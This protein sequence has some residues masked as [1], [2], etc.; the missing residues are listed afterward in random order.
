MAEIPPPECIGI[1]SH[2]KGLL[3]PEHN[4]A[5]KYTHNYL[6][7]QCK[8]HNKLG[9]YQLKLSSPQERYSQVYSAGQASHRG[10]NSIRLHQLNAVSCDQRSQQVTTTSTGARCEATKGRRTWMEMNPSCGILC[11][12]LRKW[13]GQPGAKGLPEE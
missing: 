9:K 13:M 6:A 12:Y 1:A 3:L 2:F 4:I 11:T 10:G 8:V 7:L 5:Q